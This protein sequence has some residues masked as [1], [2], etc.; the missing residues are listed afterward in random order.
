MSFATLIVIPKNG[1]PIIG[2][3]NQPIFNESLMGGNKSYKLNGKIDKIKHC[4]NMN[5][6][7][8][9][10]TDHLNIGKYQNPGGF[11]KL[12]RKV[13]LYR[14][15]DDCYG[16]YLVA[17]GFA[18]IIKIDPVVNN[19]DSL[20]L[21]PIINCASGVISDSQDRVYL[22]ILFQTF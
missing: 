5:K 19:W 15:W 12:I 21:I 2:L 7:I 4:L 11:E 14:N 9:L 3:I 10:T 6:S 18:D 13:Q 8:L 22:V 16:Y 20:A 17:K 1:N